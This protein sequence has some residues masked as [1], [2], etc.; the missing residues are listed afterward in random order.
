M[1]RI[2]QR[3]GLPLFS[4]GTLFVAWEMASR[5]RVINTLLF[6]P[7]SNV[8]AAL[9]SMVRDGTLLT[10]S[11]VSIWRVLLG[12]S[13]GASVGILIGLLTGRLPL[14]HSTLSPVIH[15]FRPLPPVAIIPLVIVW[16]GIGDVGK[17]FSISLAVFFPVWMST[18]IGARDIA[19]EYLWSAALLTTSPIIIFVRIIFPA[20]LPFIV[21]G[22]RTSIAVAFV[23]IFVSEL[24]G[25][26]NGLGYRISITQ[27]A[28]RVDQMMAG[29]VMLA[30]LN[31][32]CDSIFTTVMRRLFPWISRR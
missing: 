14:F 11:L 25:A 30:L 10:D 16:F 32:M 7:P 22:I 12:V 18:H 27:L 3:V 26:Q 15:L 17:V 28:Y 2:L 5:M 29:L 31:L 4:V 19:R 20:A 21:A 23:M 1:K 9:W 6:P 13:I 8:T 24:A